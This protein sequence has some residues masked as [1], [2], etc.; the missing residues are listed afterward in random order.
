MGMLEASTNAATGR[1]LHIWG[2]RVQD[3]IETQ[4]STG[5]D[6]IAS[7]PVP[8]SMFQA[9][10][11]LAVLAE[12]LALALYPTATSYNDVGILLSSL[13]DQSVASRSSETTG[14]GLSRVYFEAGLEVYPRD[15]HLLTN[16]GSYWK[17][18][19]NYEKAIRFVSLSSCVVT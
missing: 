4:V 6:H 8:C 13:D 16:L 14:R 1:L 5:K 9:T 15:A 18:E 3:F 7:A 12:Y 17:K 11:S 10:R 2:M 19:G